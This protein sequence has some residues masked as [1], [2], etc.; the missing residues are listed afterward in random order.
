MSILF[1]DG[2]IRP[3]HQSRSYQLATAF[4]EAFAQK[5]GQEIAYLD[6]KQE[7]LS[8]LDASDVEL[9]E[10]VVASKNFAHPLAKY[11]RQFAQAEHIVIAAPYW[12]LSFPA[13]LKIYLEYVCACGIS[14]CYDAHGVVPLCQCKTLTYITASGGEIYPG[15]NLGYD[16]VATLSKALFGIQNIRFLSAENLDIQGV[17]TQKIMSDA[18]QNAKI[19]A[20]Q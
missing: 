13:T 3:Q 17:D 14:F 18:I 12:D 15:A 8:P 4:L 16:Y 10:Q 5:Q 19:L 9:R 11:A 20:E 2:T 6:L 1:I 7:H